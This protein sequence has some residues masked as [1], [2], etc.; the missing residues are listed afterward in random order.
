L[1]RGNNIPNNEFDNILKELKELLKNNENIMKSTKN[2]NRI[3]V[4]GPE[5]MKYVLEKAGKKNGKDVY[6]P[7]TVL[8]PYMF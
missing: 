8:A 4:V 3:L 6:I 1:E 5:G 7:I 2:E